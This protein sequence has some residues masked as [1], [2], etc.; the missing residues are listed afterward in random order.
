MTTKAIIFNRFVTAYGITHDR[1]AF[2]AFA[3]QRCPIAWTWNDLEKVWSE[4]NLWGHIGIY[5][6]QDAADEH[7]TQL[8]ACDRWTDG[9]GIRHDPQ[10]DASY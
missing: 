7:A 3:K 8:A 4:F 6:A 1:L 10:F 9:E 5:A 2:H